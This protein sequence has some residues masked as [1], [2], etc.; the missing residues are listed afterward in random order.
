MEGYIDENRW[1][2]LSGLPRNS[3]GIDWKFS[4][5]HMLPFQYNT[6]SGYIKIEQ[7][8]T[9]PNK[10][11]ILYITI[12]KYVPCPRK[13][14][15]HQLLYCQIHRLVSNRI[16]DVAPHLIPYLKNPIDAYLYSYQSNKKIWIKCPICGY[17]EFIAVE[18]LYLQGK[19]CPICS[20]GISYPEKFMMSVFHQ[21]GVDYIK[22]ANKSISGFEWAMSY[23]YD[24]S[25]QFNDDK[26]IVETDGGFHKYQLDVDIK[27]DTL[28]KNNGFQIIRI[29]CDYGHSDRYQFI[30]ENIINSPLK[31]MFDLSDIDWDLCNKSAIHT[32]V[33]DVCSLWEMD[34]LSTKEI[35][36]KTGL[37]ASTI[38]KYL[39]YGRDIGLC[40]T[41]DEKVSHQRGITKKNIQYKRIIDNNEVVL[42]E[43]NAI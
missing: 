33:K 8:E 24:F 28:A 26:F 2:D 43:E 40:P 13:V 39:K 7:C 29:D 9:S 41:Y 37:S 27:K 19:K 23:R 17:T 15:I 35:C 4:V 30:K 16:A 42:K 31:D 21:L 12:D 34:G 25:F 14:H 10:R 38:W 32:I 5:G 22:E 36:Y 11:P 1:I 20:D 18:K 3:W 6:A